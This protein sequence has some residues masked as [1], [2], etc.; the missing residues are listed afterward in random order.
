MQKITI[1]LHVLDF[2]LFSVLAESLFFYI[3]GNKLS[4][5]QMKTMMAA[6]TLAEERHF[7][8]TGPGA[9]LNLFPW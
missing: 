6:Q 3:T 9:E 7:S 2:V 4:D 5:K 1:T 8:N